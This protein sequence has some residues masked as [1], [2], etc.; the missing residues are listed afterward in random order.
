LVQVS[1]PT[2]TC[3]QKGFFFV[4]CCIDWNTE[5]KVILNKS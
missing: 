2:T 1:P 5:A 3:I 4:V